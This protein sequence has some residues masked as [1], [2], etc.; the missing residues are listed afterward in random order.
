[1]RS[2]LYRINEW[3]RWRVI[4]VIDRFPCVCWTEAVSW[5]MGW[6]EYDPTY[7]L[8]NY[9]FG[10]WR[11]RGTAGQCARKGEIPYCGK[12]TE[13]SRRFGDARHVD[14]RRSQIQ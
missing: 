5:A 7:S 6:G 1:M 9:L 13:I 8:F 2:F 12:C 11:L 10:F 14:R 4:C 3:A